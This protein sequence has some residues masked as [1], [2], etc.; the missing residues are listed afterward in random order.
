MFQYKNLLRVFTV[1]VMFSLL[2]SGWDGSAASAKPPAPKNIIIMISDG[3]GYNTNLAASYYR[4]GK[5]DQQEYHHFPFKHFMS[6]YA[7]ANSMNPTSADPCYG[8]SMYDPSVAWTTFDY[9]RFCPTDSASAATAMS[10]GVKTYNAA[11]NMDLYG[12]RLENIIERAE[13]VGK[14]TGVVSTVELSHATPAGFVAHNLNRNNYEALANEMIWQSQVDVIMGAGNP[15]FDDNGNM[16]T[17]PSS[18]HYRYVGGMAT[19]D[20]LAAGTAV[21]ADADQDGQPDAWTLIQSREA[22]QSLASGPTPKRLIGVPQVYT[23]LQQARSGDGNADPFV[24]PMTT[25][26]PTLTEMTLAA[27]NVLDND[28][29]GFV[30]MIEGGAVD[31]AG[32][33]NQPGRIIE[34]Q[35]DFD[36]AVEAVI[37]WVHENSNWGETLLIITGDHETGY[38]TGPNSGAGGAAVWYPLV[39]NGAGVVPGM[40][41]NSG[42]HTNSLIPFYAKGGD[43]RWFNKAATGMDP[44]YGTYID[45]TDIGKVI[46]QLLSGK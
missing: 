24:V 22:F 35:I 26:V 46:F 34:E 13:Q 1:L 43:A 14:A 5:A 23:T 11:I 20:S 15:W 29:D 10:T 32:H 39:N 18:S 38:L 33:A 42:D 36:L 25:T 27:F 6:T 8:K 19:W 17:A 21:G 9:V 37:D 7:L 44:V 30:V 45:N 16:R 3:M 31:W 2:F 28:P 12:N 4:F 41:F 40:Q